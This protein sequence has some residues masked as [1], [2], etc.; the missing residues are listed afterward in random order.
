MTQLQDDRATSTRQ[1]RFASIDD[2]LREIDAI[3]EA[4]RAG[5]LQ[6]IG[7]WTAGQNLAHLAAWIEYGYEGYPIAAPPWPIRMILKM[8]LGRYLKKGMPRGVRI[9]RVP[10]GTYGQDDMPVEQAA[11]RLKS[12]FQQLQRKEPCPFHSPAFGPMSYEKRVQLNLRHAEL[13]LS[14]LTF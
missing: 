10:Q 2:A 3:V 13:H 8:M 6:T 12:A 7:Q 9:P 14:N 4:E 1:L 11:E 5:R